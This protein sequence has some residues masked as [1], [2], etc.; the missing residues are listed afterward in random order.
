MKMLKSERKLIEFF[1]DKSD[2]LVFL[3]V[4][5]GGMA[6]RLLFRNTDINES[7]DLSLL[8]RID[9]SGIIRRVIAC[10]FEYLLAGLV[11]VMVAG[12][13]GE[14]KKFITTY[15]LVLFSLPL[16][17][18]SSLMGRL[19]VIY[20]FL[21]VLAVFFTLRENFMLSG[22][23]LCLAI[24]FD[25]RTIII[26]PFCLYCSVLDGVSEKRE[27]FIKVTKVAL[28]SAVGVLIHILV[29]KLI[30]GSERIE[31]NLY[32]RNI[33][34]WSFLSYAPQDSG[35][36]SV[37]AWVIACIA[38]VGL[39]CFFK[40]QNNK[41]KEMTYMVLFISTLAATLLM[42]YA[43][44]GSGYLCVIVT[45]LYICQSDKCIIPA[46]LILLMEAY[47]NMSTVYGEEILPLSIQGMACVSVGVLIYVLKK[48]DRKSIQT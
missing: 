21:A 34:L 7:M 17:L 33:S 11:A 30:Y 15:F 22:L 48:S 5:L 23:I 29:E 38:I 26:L 27:G 13:S 24:I 1:E 42:P 18:S 3:T 47:I 10:V 8:N 4:S 19:D 2:I 37:Y 31:I 46:A 32:G 14:R 12:D 39:I 25:L 36:Y 45:V 40:E 20:A 28:P 41:S 44:E 35:I 43:G 9:I 6:L 16:L